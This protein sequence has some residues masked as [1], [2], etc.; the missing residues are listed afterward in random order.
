M[1]HRVQENVGDSD[2]RGPEAAMGVDQ[3]DIDSAAMSCQ[4]RERLMSR[5]D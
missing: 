2:S 3:L 1:G 5:P 4:R